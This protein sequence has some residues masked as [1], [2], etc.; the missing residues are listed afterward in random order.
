MRRNSSTQNFVDSALY[1][2]VLL[3][4]DAFSSAYLFLP[5]LFGILFLSFVRYYE[6]ERYYSLF[7]FTLILCVMEANKGLTPMILFCVYCLAYMFL[8]NKI[9]KI[10]KYVNIFE[11]IYIPSVYFALLVLNSFFGASV[12]PLWFLA[13]YLILEILLMVGIWILNTK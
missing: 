3:I 4:Y 9:I 13:W 11:L 5:P 6:S 7:F 10:F 8:H 1:F 2:A 12:P